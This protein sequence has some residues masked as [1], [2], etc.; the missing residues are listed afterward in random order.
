MKNPILYQLP[1]VDGSD[2]VSYKVL[3]SVF[4]NSDGTV[5]QSEYSS[6]PGC[7][8]ELPIE[9]ISNTSIGLIQDVARLRDVYEKISGKP[10]FCNIVKDISN[11]GKKDFTD[12]VSRVD[13]SDPLNLMTITDINVQH[14]PGWYCLDRQVFYVTA[15]VT[16]DKNSLLHQYIQTDVE[17]Y[18]NT[19]LTI[20]STNQYIKHGDEH[21]CINTG[22]ATGL[23]SIQTTSRLE[24]ARHVIMSRIIDT[25]FSITT[26]IDSSITP[27]NGLVYK[28]LYVGYPIR[29]FYIYY[30]EL[31][32]DVVNELEV[33]NAVLHNGEYRVILLPPGDTN[34]DSL[35]WLQDI[36]EKAKN[37]LIGDVIRYSDNGLPV[38]V[39][40]IRLDV[41]TNS[42]LFK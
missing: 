19:G 20:Q 26:I 25:V 16:C 1:V 38:I 24:L 2:T 41:N 15:N 30:G 7:S 27:N 29:M 35:K 21:V 14:L 42:H 40:F 8:I 18:F 33:Y 4:L 23:L 34:P 10:Y 31:N 5:Q 36:H 37:V 11:K 6:L 17:F 3:L 13:L 9:A 12:I 28:P 39:N 22:E 32:V